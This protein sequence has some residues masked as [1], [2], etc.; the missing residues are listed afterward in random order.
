M[1][2]LLYILVLLDWRE[3]DGMVALGLY[4]SLRLL[5]ILSLSSTKLV[6]SVPAECFAFAK[7]W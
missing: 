5:F 6:P 2:F 7:V 4:R 3:A 1:F